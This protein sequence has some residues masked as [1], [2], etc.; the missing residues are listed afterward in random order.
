MKY[1]VVGIDEGQF[2]EDIVDFSQDLANSGTIVIVAAL[3]ST[4]QR[5]PFG[6]IINLVPLAEKVYK[7]TAVCVYCTQ[8]A[9]FTQR[10]IESQEVELIGGA[11][12]YK[13]VCRQCFHNPPTISSKKS[14]ECASEENESEL[15]NPEKE[16]F[17]EKAKNL[18]SV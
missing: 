10:T 12:S 11:E 7:L 1:D 2:F 3:D 4:F 17:T 6:N 16:E 8:P 14:S 13:P 15:R 9:A 5:K 18:V